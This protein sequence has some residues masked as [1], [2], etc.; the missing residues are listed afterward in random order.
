MCSTIAATRA[1]SF[2][3]PRFGAVASRLACASFANAPATS[4]TSE[5]ARDCAEPRRGKATGA[6]RGDRRA[7]PCRR[8]DVS[9]TA[10]VRAKNGM[11]ELASDARIIRNDRAQ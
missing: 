5:T 4:A 10:S 11:A 8:A 7:H 9:V 3:S 1:G 6:G 2:P